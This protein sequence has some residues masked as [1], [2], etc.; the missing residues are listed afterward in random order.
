MNAPFPEMGA[1]HVLPRLRNG[2]AA[3][4]VRFVCTFPWWVIWQVQTFATVIISF[5]FCT[6]LQDYSF[7]QVGFES[8]HTLFSSFCL[9]SSLSLPLENCLYAPA[10]CYLICKGYTFLFAVKIIC[11]SLSF[12]HFIIRPFSHLPYCCCHFSILGSFHIHEHVC[13][14][15]MCKETFMLGSTFSCHSR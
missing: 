14:L 13:D 7:S 11:A 5:K 15:D 9:C 3:S 10:F 1:A 6:A 8:A 4:H 12:Y 2:Y